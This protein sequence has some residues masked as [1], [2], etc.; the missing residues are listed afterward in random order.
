MKVTNTSNSRTP[1][2]II[3]TCWKIHLQRHALIICRTLTYKECVFWL[4]L[5]AFDPSQF[6]QLLKKRGRK[7]L[8]FRIKQLV[9]LN[10]LACGKS[11]WNTDTFRKKKNLMLAN[12]SFV[13]FYDSLLQ[14]FLVYFKFTFFCCCCS[15]HTTQGV[16]CRCVFLYSVSWKS[17]LEKLTWHV[18]FLSYR[19]IFPFF[20]MPLQCFSPCVCYRSQ[21]EVHLFIS[22]IRILAL[23]PLNKTVTFFF[24]PFP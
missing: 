2:L 9:I 1:P 14:T 7:Q 22:L 13:R 15:V 5:R 18:F 8:A 23:S 16:Y 17:G 3:S 10:V 12:H 20:L 11:P 19:D 4:I 6:K 24:P 21:V